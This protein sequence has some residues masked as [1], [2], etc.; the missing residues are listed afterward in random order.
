MTNCINYFTHSTTLPD[1]YQRNYENDLPSAE[2]NPSDS[3]SKAVRVT[4]VVLPFLSLY[5]PMWRIISPVMNSVKIITHLFASIKSLKQGRTLSTLGNLVQVAF[6]ATALVAS[7]LQF[8][9]GLVISTAL[10]AILSITHFIEHLIEGSYDKA[11][12]DLLQLVSSS[13]YLAIIFTGSLEVAL[14]SLLGQTLLSLWQSGEEFVEGNYI[15]GTAKLL[16]GLIRYSEIWST[17]SYTPP[18]PKRPG[19]P[20]FLPYMP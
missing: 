12:E 2:A 13:L 17:L 4:L 5:K 9:L 3:C 8:T 20:D 10:D 14:A 6:T 16:F 7:I 1:Y 18:R 11:I 19:R 15:E